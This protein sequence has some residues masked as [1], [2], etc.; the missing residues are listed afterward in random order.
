MENS[1]K[2]DGKVYNIHVK[3]SIT[4]DFNANDL[5]YG[6]AYEGSAGLS[7]TAFRTI[8]EKNNQTYFLSKK[9]NVSGRFYKIMVSC[10]QYYKCIYVNN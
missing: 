5:I 6:I 3:D 10:N 1:P 7:F 2:L 8:C 9:C 4:K